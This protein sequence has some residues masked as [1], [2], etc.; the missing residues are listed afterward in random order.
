MDSRVIIILCYCDLCM[1]FFSFF[2]LFYTNHFLSSSGTNVRFVGIGNKGLGII[3]LGRSPGSLVPL[4]RKITRYI[5]I[6]EVGYSSKIFPSEGEALG[7]NP[8]IFVITT[9]L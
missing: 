6:G 2:L 5:A 4:A 1:Y 9:P 7:D 8:K 3:I